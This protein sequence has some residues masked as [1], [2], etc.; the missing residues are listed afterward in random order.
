MRCYLIT[1][2]GAS[3]ESGRRLALPF[4]ISSCFAFAVPVVLQAVELGVAAPA[5]T[6]LNGYALGPQALF[7]PDNGVD[8]AILRTQAAAGAK[9]RINRHHI[10]SPF[11]YCRKMSNFPQKS[12]VQASVQNHVR[13]RQSCFTTPR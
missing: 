12:S 13:L 1:D 2:I 9:R 5:H 6:D 8:G 11:A 4:V 10:C 3:S 7:C